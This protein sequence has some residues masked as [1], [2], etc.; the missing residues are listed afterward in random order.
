MASYKDILKEKDNQNWLKGSLALRITKAGLRGLVEGESHRVQQNIH[1]SVLHARHLAAGTTCSLCLTEHVLPCPTRGLCSHPRNCKYH[2]TPFKIHR[3]CPSQIC[4]DFRDE[5]CAVHRYSGPSWKNTKA[6]Q[7]CTN[8]WQVAKCFMPPDGYHD[9]TSYDETDFNGI[10]S[11]M[12]NCTEFQR[13][14]SFPIGNQPNALTEARV[15]GRNIRHSP[16]LKLTDTDLADYFATLNT[17]L[18]DST[19]LASDMDA[20]QAVLKLQQLEKGTLPITTEEV[21]ELLEEARATVETGIESGK[22]QLAETAETGKKDIESVVLQGKT[23]IESGTRQLV[24]TAETGKKDIEGVVSHG[25]LQFEDAMKTGKRNLEGVV[26]QGK[27]HLEDTMTTA[28]VVTERGKLEI[29]DAVAKSRDTV[30]VGKRELE[31]ALQKIKAVST[32]SDAEQRGDLRQ[33]LV[34][35]YQKQLNSAPISPLLSDKDER[36]DKFYVP[37]KIEEKDHRRLGDDQQ[38]NGSPISSYKQI[39]CKENGLANTVFV[40]GEAGMGKSSFSAMCTIKWAAQFSVSCRDAG[41][42]GLDED[43]DEKTSLKRPLLNKKGLNQRISTNRFI[44]RSLVI[45]KYNVQREFQELFDSLSVD[46]QSFVRSHKEEFCELLSKPKYDLFQDEDTLRDIEF[47]FHIKLRDCCESCELSDMI[48]DQ[49]IN[50]IYRPD[51]MAAGYDTMISVL[52]NRKCVVI[53]DGLDE[54]SHPT[55]RKCS[56]SLEDKVIPHLSQTLDATVLITSRPWRLSQNRVKDTKI[57]AYLEIKGVASTPLLVQKTLVCLNGKEADKRLCLD[58]IRFVARRRLVRLLS[59]PIIVLLLVCLW[60]EGV[61]E[62]FSFCDIYA[63]MM[64]M[65]FGRKSLPVLSVSPECTPLLKCFKQTKHVQNY[66]NI[67]LKLAQLAFEKLFSRD[68]KSSL[69]FQNIDCLTQEELLFV[70][71]SGIMRETKSQS[72]IR[73]SSSFSFIHK[74]VQ[75][76]LAAVHSYHA[77]VHEDVQEF[78]PIVYPLKDSSMADVSHVFLF[79]CGINRE[80]AQYLSAMMSNAVSEKCVTWMYETWVKTVQQALCAGYREALANNVQNIQLELM[81]FYIDRW[82]RD[83]STLKTLISMNKSQLRQITIIGHDDDFSEEELQ[84]L[85]ISSK[86]TLTRVE[87]HGRAGQYDLSACCRLQYLTISSGPYPS[88]ITI[89]E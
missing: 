38:Q 32:L 14:M 4:D 48:R 25:K 78:L 9:V 83:L 80:V 11:V 67:V 1:S 7:W 6:N 87:I 20:Q 16:D 70:L 69:V 82:T 40:V 65:M 45:K 44:L 60:F 85:F 68:R 57:G 74:T 46:D 66:Y 23:A 59:V 42:R 51:E 81:C 33:R 71:K 24:E 41:G 58:F 52:S 49:L 27:L 12:I 30:Q 17:L 29:E 36:L 3:P 77:A 54:W 63:Y 21:R 73:K 37:P 89:N 79:M 47:M 61:H 2:N 76:F 8:H 86:N 75:E 13:R 26:T 18:T 43:R 84:A 19:F 39:F 56:C 34:K 10:I 64:D 72:L 28:R 5:I 88:N 53:V 62:S 35:Y 31:E 55:E 22:R 15:I 50:I